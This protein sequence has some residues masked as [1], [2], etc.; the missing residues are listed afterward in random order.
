MMLPQQGE[1]FLLLKNSNVINW[2]EG[3]S[4]EIEVGFG[5]TKFIKISKNGHEELIQLDMNSNEQ[6]KREGTRK[7][8]GV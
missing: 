6:E 3:G 1:D 5:P 8:Q 4:E 2:S 7:E